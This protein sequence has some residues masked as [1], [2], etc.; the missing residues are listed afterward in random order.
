[1]ARAERRLL[2]DVDWVL[3]VLVTALALLGLV[4]VASATQAGLD[5]R[6]SWRFVAKQAGFMAAGFI[7][8]A[9][10]AFVDP[11]VLRRASPYLYVLNLGLLLAVKL[12][13]RESLGAQRWLQVGPVD[14]QPSEFSKLILILTL[15]AVISR[16]ERGVDG[17]LAFVKAGL[18]VLP[19]FGLVLLQPDL[20]TS[21]VYVAIF[22]GMAYAGGLAGWKVA[23]VGGLGLGAAVGWIVAHLRFG[24][25][26]PLKDYQ[27]KRLIVFTNPEMDPLGAGWHVLQSEIAIGS[28]GLSGRGLFSGSQNQLNYLPEQHTDFIFSVLAEELGFAGGAVVVLL[29]LAI[30]WRAARIMAAGRDRYC[31]L[32][33]GGIAAMLTFHVLVN[34]GM[35]MGVM[36]VTGVP[37][38]FL[39]YGGSSLLT[40][41]AAMGLLLNVGMRR[42]KILF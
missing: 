3:V 17:W 9:S 40:N 36:P 1:M 25:P 27:L 2:R 22:M 26:I 35:T 19:P 8:A 10:L 14:L 18:Y 12:F 15:A 20:G 5:D 41:S 42:R 28:G 11:E 7:L 30:L 13:G 29:Y 37:L 16:W 6:S 39:S 21:L 34:V 33:A 4:L 23:A 24:L 31:S 32:M 38:P